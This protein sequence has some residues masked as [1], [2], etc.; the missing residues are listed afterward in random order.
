ME[1]QYR[2]QTR[3]SECRC[4]QRSRWNNQR[5]QGSDTQFNYRYG[6]GLPSGRRGLLGPGGR[7]QLTRYRHHFRISNEYV[8]P[9][10]AA[11]FHEQ[12][13]HRQRTFRGGVVYQ[14]EVRL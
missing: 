5:R 12:A 3:H 1:D 6:Y 14:L 10:Y 2:G 11:E 9:G 7:F 8:Q 13:D 4:L